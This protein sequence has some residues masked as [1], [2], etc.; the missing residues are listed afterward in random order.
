MGRLRAFHQGLKETGYVEGENVAII[1]RWAEKGDRFS[2]SGS[3]SLFGQ[4]CRYHH[5]GCNVS[6][7]DAEGDMMRRSFARLR[8]PTFGSWHL[9]F[10]AVIP[11]SSNPA[12]NEGPVRARLTRR[13]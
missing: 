9:R 4:Y 12:L 13:A 5:R 10:G 2:G 11:T 1:Y 6:V 8:N 7:N 3:K